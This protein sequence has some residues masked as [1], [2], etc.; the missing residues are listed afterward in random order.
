MQSYSQKGLFGLTK[1]LRTV[2]AKLLI[3][4]QRT[5]MVWQSCATPTDT[6]EDTG[7]VG[8]GLGKGPGVLLLGVMASFLVKDTFGHNDG[9]RIIVGDAFG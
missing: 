1:Q 4:L 2:N 7:C 5:G 8:R 6:K 9:N 3:F